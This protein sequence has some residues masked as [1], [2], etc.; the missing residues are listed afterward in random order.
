MKKIFLTLLFVVFS[1]ATI[2]TAFS[3]EAKGRYFLEG[4]GSVHL[5]NAKTGQGGTIRYRDPDG[6]YLKK[7]QSE[8]NRIFG[9]PAHSQEKTSLRLIAL[10]DFLEDHFKSP[11]IK[12][13]SGYRSPEYNDG[14]RNK[15]RLAAKTSMHIEG[16]AA[17]IEI[18]G[19]NGKALWDYVRSLDCCGAGY[20]H[21]R[22]IHIDVGNSRFWDE[23]T[24]KVDQDLGGHNK[25]LL[26]R[27]EYDYYQSGEKVGLSISRVTD[28]P[29]G[30]RSKELFPK[31]GCHT[32][33]DRK[34]AKNLIW[35]L[36]KDFKKGEKIQ[37]KFKICNKDFPEMPDQIV[38]NPLVVR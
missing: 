31:E 20:Y 1:F 9:I 3:S 14:L 34:S 11:A 19:V 16:M 33:P 32:L 2:K 18:E 22:G 5:I 23:K 15:G 30:I 26:L 12:I 17:D 36:P 10:L 25:L 28:Y 27:T 7:G 29:I 13:V 21:G 35:E 6:S 37:M 24:T 38:S 8:V 4:D